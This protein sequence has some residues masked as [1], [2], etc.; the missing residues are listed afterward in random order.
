MA[1]QTLGDIAYGEYIQGIQEDPE[2]SDCIKYN[3][4]YYGGRISNPYDHGAYI[5]QNNWNAT[6]VSWCAD[7]LLCS[8]FA[9]IP[10]TNS[11]WQMYNWFVEQNLPLYYPWSVLDEC[12]LP[13]I[14][15]GDILFFLT[16]TGSQYVGIVSQVDLW[17]VTYIVGDAGGRIG[18]FQ[19][20]YAEL[21]ESACFVH[22][23]QQEQDDVSAIILFL[24]R[25]MQLN[26][27]AIC[28]IVTNIIFESEGSHNIIGDSGY[29]AGICQWQGDRFVSLRCFCDENGYDWHSL[30]GQLYYLKYELEGPYQELLVRLKNVEDSREG[31]YEAAYLFCMHYERPE[32][33]EPK[34]MTRGYDAR[35]VYYPRWFG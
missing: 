27:A 12:G 13:R 18:T 1:D 21:P 25:E 34:A 7:Q 20:S 29:S 16:D 6:F 2:G 33:A 17:G 28:G 5:Q 19:T 35:S 15:K 9:A 4:W 30:E 23:S 24:Q 10:R 3:E 22:L 32:N 8:S 31:A 26:S 14:E 11:V